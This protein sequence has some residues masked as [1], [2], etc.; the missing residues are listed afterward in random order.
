[1]AA[2]RKDPGYNAGSVSLIA[3]SAEAQSDLERQVEQAFD[4]ELLDVAMRRVK[5]RV[6][7]GTWDAFQL[8]AIEGLSGVEAAQKLGIPVAHVFVAKHR[9]QKLLQEEV[10]ILKEGSG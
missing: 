4:R 6:K 7:P 10:G 2:R 5:N 3:D 8:T 1:M 9:V